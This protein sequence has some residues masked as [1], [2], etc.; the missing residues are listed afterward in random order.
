MKCKEMGRNTTLKKRDRTLQAELK[1]FNIFIT[2][3]Y[4][5]KR[6]KIILK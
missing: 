6:Y 2:P 3:E 1:K 5:L 4:H